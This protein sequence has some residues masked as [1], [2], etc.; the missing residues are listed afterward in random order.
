MISWFFVY[1]YTK[2]GDNQWHITLELNKKN[3]PS[4][5]EM[6]AKGLITIWCNLQ[7]CVQILNKV[8]L[9]A[10]KSTLL[11]I[12]NWTLNILDNNCI[13]KRMLHRIEI[14]L[15]PIWRRRKKWNTRCTFIFESECSG[16]CHHDC[17]FVW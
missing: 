17:N 13:N 16:G 10:L 3:F 9:F 5:S 11:C 15:T 12:L 1:F 7:K 8:A 2:K 6:K 14:V 4:P